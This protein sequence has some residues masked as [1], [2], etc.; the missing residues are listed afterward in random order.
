MDIFGQFF[1]KPLFSEAF[2]EREM[3][4]VDSEYHL[5]YSLDKTREEFLFSN[6]CKKGHPFSHFSWG[7]LESLNFGTIKEDLLNFYERNYSSNTMKLVYFLNQFLKFFVRWFI[8]IRKL[9]KLKV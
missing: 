1:I 5:N 8:G 6:T 4:A 3:K 2:I 9:N 7:S